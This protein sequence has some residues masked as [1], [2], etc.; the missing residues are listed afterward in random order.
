MKELPGKRNS[1]T[2]TEMDKLGHMTK[3]QATKR[4]YEIVEYCNTM[5]IRYCCAVQ[6]VNELKQAFAHQ[7]Q[8]A[9]KILKQTR[10]FVV[11]LNQQPM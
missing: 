1:T 5:N 6:S 4:K 3:S 2:K 11:E 9:L 7:N 8:N 10:L